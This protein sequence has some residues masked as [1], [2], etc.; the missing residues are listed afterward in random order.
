[1][2]DELKNRI[3][4][5]IDELRASLKK[6]PSKIEVNKES[7]AESTPEDNVMINNNAE[8]PLDDLRFKQYVR[9]GGIIL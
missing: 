9:F 4:S 3:K 2:L 1:M 8:A 7:E 5:G 6:A